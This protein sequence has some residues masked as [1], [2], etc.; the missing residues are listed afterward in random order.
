MEGGLINIISYGANEL[1]L[2]ESPEITF[3][4][5]IFRRHTNYVKESV[6]IGIKNV[7][8]G[9]EID[10]FVPKYADLIG[11]TYLMMEVPEIH[12][13]KTDIATNLNDD[14]ITFLTN[15]W[16]T[17]LT[18]DQLN[19]VNNYQTII[20][21]MTINTTGY[22]TAVNNKNIINQTTEEYV[23]AILASI[24]FSGTIQT[25]YWNA[26]NDAK[27][28]ENSIGNIQYDIILNYH[29]SDIS[30][31]L[32]NKIVIPNDY[33]SYTVEQV[34]KMVNQAMKI[35]VQVKNY[36]F[37]KNREKTELDI[38]YSS[39]YAKFAWVSRLGHSMIDSIEVLIGG[40][41]IVVHDDV[42]IDNYHYL[43]NNIAK[44]DLYDKMI[45]NI[46]IMKTFDRNEKPKYLIKLPLLLWFCKSSSSYFP[47]S[48]LQYHDFI[49]RVKLKQIERC[50][51]IETL[52]NKDND[53]NPIEITQLTL[54]DIWDN[55]GYK[56]R[57]SLYVDY[58]FLDI[59]ERKR[60]IKMGHEYIVDTVQKVTIENANDKNQ[61]ITLNFNGPS[62]QLIWFCQ[63][64]S[65]LNDDSFLN[66][67]NFVY[68]INSDG[69]K[70]PI[71]NSKLTIQNYDRFNSSSD[72]SNY[73]DPYI[74]NTRTPQDGTNVYSFSL[75]PEE[76]QPSSICNFTYISNQM[77]Y[78]N[79]NDN[80][81]KYYKSDIDP[82]IIYGSEQDEQLDTSVNITIYTIK[83]DVIRILGGMALKAFK[84][85]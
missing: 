16:N 61:I 7:D 21:F 51:Y 62:K 19:I 68:S 20:D 60:F 1:F 35:S 40:E 23:D 43:T 32:N 78:L 33:S 66:K 3:F 58:V 57:L 29:V 17:P 53:D 9:D 56:I 45:G 18:S 2:T 77:L 22:R 65:Y 25:D 85:T 80:V 50:A 36:F 10:I 71:Q 72:Q 24:V 79:L 6:E 73:L 8:F 67:L 47:I 5:F 83:Y 38:E 37:I 82:N 64:T 30:Y 11:Q 63:K 52:P 74:Y 81:F 13:L 4:K 27:T 69:T 48:S 49:I 75:Y 55:M 39:N 34:Y 54:S 26:L 59:D 12:L 42:F 84:Y 15:P 28:Y 41:S 44:D 70:N 31:M 46:D 76:R 14:E